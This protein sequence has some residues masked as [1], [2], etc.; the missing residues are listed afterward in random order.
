MGQDTH[1]DAQS[2]LNDK[3]EKRPVVGVG[4]EDLGSC[5]TAIKDVEAVAAG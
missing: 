5:V 4:E 1:G 3:A 2:D